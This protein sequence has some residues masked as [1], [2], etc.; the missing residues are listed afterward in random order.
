MTAVFP[1]LAGQDIS[2]T[3]KP[4]FSTIIA[5]HASGREVRDALYQNPI[6]QFEVSFNALDSS[7]GNIYGGGVGSQSL[8]A[9]MGLFLACQGQYSPFLFTD[10]TDSAVTAGGFATGDGTTTAFTMARSMGA[11]LEPVGWVTGI[12]EITVGGSVVSSSIYSLTTPNTLTF[13][14]PPASGAAIAGT[15]A[16]AFLCRFDDDAVEFEQFMS[17]AWNARSIKFKSLRAF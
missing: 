3:K 13:V 9:I 10:P 11:F 8:Q 16:Y 5:P 17:Q 1:T 15:F 14:T 7:P 2:F 4:T 6:W 12:S